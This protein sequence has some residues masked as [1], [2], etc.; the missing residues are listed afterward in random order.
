MQK[1]LQMLQLQQQLNDNTN[2]KE[3]EK[4]ITKNGKIIDWK[5]CAY[6]ECAE[7]I[8]SYPWKHWKSI[9]A[10]PDYENIK[11]E[12]VDIWHFI[13]SLA[14]QEYY[15][16]NLG[17]I[18]KLAQDITN[19]PNYDAFCQDIKPTDKNYYEQIECIEELI[20][21]LFCQ[22]T[23]AKIIESFFEVA[24]QSSLNL[25]TLYKLYIG[26]NILN[27]FRQDHGYKQG[28]YIKIWN[29]KEDNV[30]MQEILDSQD[31]ISAN[32]LYKGLQE[33]YQSL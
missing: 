15:L 19:T 12:S 1:I 18:N 11:I 5:R 14:L 33:V 25:D 6:L 10:S 2:G 13:M 28:T 22:S 20:K 4:G 32:E 3:W 27:Q 29:G 23:T 24:I 9:D 31:D 26:K 16:G 7:L 17:D 21:D 30:I 8:E